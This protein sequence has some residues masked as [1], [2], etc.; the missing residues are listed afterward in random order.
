MAWWIPLIIAGASML[1]S[2]MSQQDTSDTENQLA[3]ISREMTQLGLEQYK[4]SQ[5]ALAPLEEA[6]SGILSNPKYL[7]ALA[8]SKISPTNASYRDIKDQVKSN[9]VLRGMKGSGL[10]GKAMGELEATRGSSAV[11]GV[12]EAQNKVF[13]E[14]QKFLQGGYGLPTAAMEGYQSAANLG[15]GVLNN[16]N[17]QNQQ[18]ADNWSSLANGLMDMGGSAGW[19]G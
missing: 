4:Q 1:G 3:D 5:D 10:E 9:M 17:T 15:L 11:A 6:W 19:W 18:T 12:R 16:L 13:A 7:T 2:S 14:K 8:E